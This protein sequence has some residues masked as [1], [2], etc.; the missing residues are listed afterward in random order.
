[1]VTSLLSVSCGCWLWSVACIAA[2]YA[3]GC[4]MA[5]GYALGCCSTSTS[6][7]STGG[8]NISCDDN[9][10]RHCLCNAA[11]LQTAMRRWQDLLTTVIGHRCCNGLH[12]ELPEPHKE[13]GLLPQ[14]ATQCAKAKLIGTNHADFS[15]FVRSVLHR[16]W[17]HLQVWPGQARC[18]TP[19][20]HRF[21][22]IPDSIQGQPPSRSSNKHKVGKCRASFGH[23]HCCASLSLLRVLQS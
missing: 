17:L 18:W 16:I 7:S 9:Y 14:V 13:G 11:L 1:M 6:T 15:P 4:A 8:G 23:V 12:T 5:L 21:Q 10:G 3:R 20:D 2:G 22:P 19:G